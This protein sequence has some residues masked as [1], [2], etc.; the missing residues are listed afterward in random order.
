MGVVKKLLFAFLILPFLWGCSSSNSATTSSDADTTASTAV[1]SKAVV[2]LVVHIENTQEPD[3]DALIAAINQLGEAEIPVS[4]GVD[5]TWLQ[6]ESRASE[7]FDAVL[8]NGGNLDVHAHDSDFYN[9]AD[10]ANLIVAM[11]YEPTTV[12]SGYTPDEADDF[13]VS[14]E[15]IQGG[16]TWQAFYL[17]GLAEP[18]HTDDDT[19]WGI[20][21]YDNGS[22]PL[23]GGGAL[24]IA[25][26]ENMVNQVSAGDYPEMLLTCGIALNPEMLTVLGETD[27]DTI[28]DIINLKNQTDS[29]AALWMTI[30]E[31]GELADSEY[32]GQDSRVEGVTDASVSDTSV[33]NIP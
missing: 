22:P 6:N 4:L 32:P 17:W 15:P 26:A 25:S 7:I 1:E 8:N 2:S 28:D 16:D 14:I 12:V 21:R 31:I 10:L 33:Y 11:G 23:I 20:T 9:R 27:G 30:Q 3:V 24:S 5:Y 18:G 29:Q 19:S 13:A